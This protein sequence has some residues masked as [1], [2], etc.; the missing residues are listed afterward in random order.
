MPCYKEPY[1]G[2][3]PLCLISVPDCHT[4]NSV[5]LERRD[6]VEKRGP[7]ALMLHPVDAAERGIQEGDRV[8][9]WNDLAQVDFRAVITE[10][11]AKGTAA[12]SGIY[13]SSQTGSSLLFNALNHERVSD[14]EATTLNDN[15]IDVKRR[16]E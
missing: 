2:A 13:S 14:M 3:Y 12:V 9:A 11:I 7:A 6:L 16:K 8:T 4:L 5:F 15:R 10:R 1:G